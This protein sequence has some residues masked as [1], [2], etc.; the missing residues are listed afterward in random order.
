ML[1]GRGARRVRPD[2]LAER[3][4][5]RLCAAPTPRRAK[6]SACGSGRSA[7]ATRRR[8]SSPTTRKPDPT[9]SGLV[10]AARAARAPLCAG[11]R[12]AGLRRPR[13][14]HRHP[15]P[16]GRSSCPVSHTRRRLPRH[17]CPMDLACCWAA[18]WTPRSRRNRWSGRWSRLCRAATTRVYRFARSGLSVQRDRARGPGAVVLAIAGDG[19][20]AYVDDD[21]ELRLTDDPDEAGGDPIVADARVVAAS[22]APGEGMAV[23]VV[24]SEGEVGTRRA[25]RPGDR[26]AHAAGTGGLATTLAALKVPVVR[27]R[28]RPPSLAGM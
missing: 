19:T 16:A 10:P 17:G 3:S 18:P 24:A 23:I 7:E 4:A 27:A 1:T 21:G 9:P 12:G 22:F 15:R 25:A 6:V 20:I 5:R 8:S 14:P 13:R 26:R 2:V 28:I 11:R